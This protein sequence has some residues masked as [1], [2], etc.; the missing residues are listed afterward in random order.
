MYTL[1]CKISQNPKAFQA[2]K[3]SARIFEIRRL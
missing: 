1:F 3:L 2:T